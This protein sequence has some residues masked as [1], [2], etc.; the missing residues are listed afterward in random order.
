M[1]D[2]TQHD[3]PSRPIPPKATLWPSAVK[4]RLRVIIGLIGLLICVFSVIAYFRVHRYVTRSSAFCVSCHF[5]SQAELDSQYHEHLNCVQC[6]HVEPGVALG[7]W[8]APGSAKSNRHGQ[9]DLNRCRDCHFETRK[10]ST[11]AKS[12]GHQNHVTIKAKLSCEKCHALKN[13]RTTVDPLTCSKCHDKV[14]VHEH[15]MS[16]VAC[17]SCH[18]FIKQ[19]NAGDPGATGC[20]TCHSGKQKPTDKGINLPKTK[21][22][23]STVV[24][25]NVNACRLCHEPH[26]PDPVNR[27]HA[28]ECAACHR[29]VVEQHIEAN[30]PT[31]KK[32]ESCHSVHGPRPK[33]PDLCVQCHQ[34]QSQ[35]TRG[36]EL[37]GKHQG[38]SGCHVAHT[39]KPKAERCIECHKP[40]RAV[41][42]TWRSEAHANCLDCHRG[43][44]SHNAAESCIRCHQAKSAHGH[45]KCTTCHAPHQDKQATK[46]C[47]NCHAPVFVTISD[48]RITKHQ[49]C[50][51]CHVSHAP[52]QAP[53]RCA[54]CHN[55]Q[56]VIVRKAEQKQHQ[57]CQSCHVQHTFTKGAQSCLR[58]HRASERGNHA[59]NCTKCHAAHG[60]PAS[61]KLDCRTCHSSVGGGRGHHI[62]C[63]S[64]HSV[65]LSRNG[66]PTC[67][68]CHQNAEAAAKAWQSKAHQ[69]CRSCHERHSSNPPKACAECHSDKTR[70]PLAKG[71][72]CAG[73]H[74]PHRPPSLGSGLC[75]SCHKKIGDMVSGGTITHQD[76]VKCHSPHSNNLPNCTT[77]HQTRVGAHNFKGHKRCDSCHSTHQVRFTGREKC[78]SC[79]TDKMNHFPN[80]ATCIACHNFR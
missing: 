43:H 76:C 16:E 27:R 73:C 50:N 33:T 64:C 4:H 68:N 36:I 31:H 17:L 2:E 34:P 77:C 23:D 46:Q 42:T 30:I 10:D 21:P 7:I 25:G 1:S 58:C 28:G 39:F 47:A 5:R 75:S 12:I 48:S 74:S 80:A 32:C 9:V 3:P 29:R 57:A 61:L 51:A 6:H 69:D 11:A 67:S 60:P 35:R 19:G 37:A 54:A 14:K 26:R 55:S 56:A 71:H 78:L 15:G 24:H 52:G 40:V 49:P 70:Q 65:H 41:F 18:Q 45:E 20:P 59:D 79:H 13:H 53:M 62:E 38:C 72:T 44:S 22:I 8:L 66:G 63:Q